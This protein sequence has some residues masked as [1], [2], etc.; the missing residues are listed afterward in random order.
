MNF[1]IVWIRHHSRTASLFS[2]IGFPF[3][4]H[5]E[6]FQSGEISEERFVRL[7]EEELSNFHESLVSRG[8]DP[9]KAATVLHS[10][11]IVLGGPGLL[12][13]ARVTDEPFEQLEFKSVREATASILES[14]EGDPTRIAEMISYLVARNS[15]LNHDY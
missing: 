11:V 8:E 10:A 6:R 13:E 15:N 9:L 3:F 1:P 4:F 14:Y 5:L 12:E 7:F 2:F